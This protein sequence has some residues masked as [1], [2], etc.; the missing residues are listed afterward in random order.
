MVDRLLACVIGMWFQL[1]VHRY[2]SLCIV[3]CRA[4]SSCELVDWLSYWLAYVT[5]RYREELEILIE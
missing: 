2:L 4:F 5:W 3:D 1:C